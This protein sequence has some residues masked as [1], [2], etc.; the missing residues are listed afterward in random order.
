MT[1]KAVTPTP[2]TPAESTAPPAQ[3]DTSTGTANTPETGADETEDDTPANEPPKVSLSPQQLNDR[4]ARAKGK[5]H[6]EQLTE[7]GVDN[8]EEA[9][10]LL[11]EARQAKLDKLSETERLQTQLADA[12]KATEKE[13][14]A[15]ERIERERELSETQNFL[16]SACK[17]AD[18]DPDVI[19]VVA[20]KLQKFIADN[21]GEDHEVTDADTKPFFDDLRSKKMQWFVAAET[22]ANTHA[23]QKEPLPSATQLPP[24]QHTLIQ[25][26]PK[27]PSEMTDAEWRTYSARTWG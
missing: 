12:N 16:N 9:K 10:T 2:T 19:E 4:L 22:P 15:R 25:P 26:P 24:T 8:I 27:P 13:R 20:P 23:K 21:F 3:A 14:K 5:A 6:K 7:L 1:G 18:L 17:K 11:E